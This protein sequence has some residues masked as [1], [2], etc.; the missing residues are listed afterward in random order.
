KLMLMSD[1]ILLRKRAIIESVNNLLKNS[2]QIE[3]HRHRNRWN[4]LSNLMLGIA[5][6]CLN[7]DKPR[8]FFHRK[9]IDQTTIAE[10]V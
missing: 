8:L 10:Y 1:K 4:F 7:P 3:H 5:N 2:C 6:Y 9:E